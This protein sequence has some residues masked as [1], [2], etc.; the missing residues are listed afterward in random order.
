MFFK[1]L[2]YFTPLKNNPIF[3]QKYITFF[4]KTL[5]GHKNEQVTRIY[6]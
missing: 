5:K 4:L 2:Y 3:Y 6:I 1:K